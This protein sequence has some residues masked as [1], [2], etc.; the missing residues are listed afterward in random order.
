MFTV[1]DIGRATGGILQGGS[2]QLVT[3][4]STDSRSV[5]PGQ[6][7][8][9]LR[10]ERFDG[11]DFLPQVAERGV[12]VAL[13]ERQWVN[14]HAAP[15][16]LTLIVVPDTLRALGDL[17]IFHRQRFELPV[18]GITG[19][20]GK[21]T[22][23]EMLASILSF[24]GPGLKTSGNLNNLI[25]LPQMLFRLSATDRWAVLEMGMSEFGEIDRL[26]EIAAP[27][28]G[29][30]TNVFPAHLETLKN[31]AGVARA[32]GE[33][34]LRL[35]SGGVAVAN[36]DDPLVAALPAAPGVHRLEFGLVRG[37]VTARDIRP[38]GLTGQQFTLVLPKGEQ[39]VRLRAF[40][41]HNI[42][43]ALGAA[44][45]AY[46]FGV[47]PSLIREGLEEF[48]PYDKR[49]KVEELPGIVLVD[50][51]YNAN[52]ASMAAAL[53]TVKEIAAGRRVVA[54][55]GDMLELGEE[56]D[57]A[58]RQLGEQVAAAADRL[59]VLGE[60]SQLVA[61]GARSAGMAEEQVSQATS[62][63]EIVALLKKEATGNDLVLVKGS[64]GMR[65][66]QVAQALRNI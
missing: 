15:P 51:S 54:V 39:Q 7:F 37:E 1:A 35:P 56:S 59:F 50:D 46:A 47:K 10:G 32:K 5:E 19:S 61:Q 6:L 48:T 17:A 33:L 36:G 60:C 16:G 63:D 22:T 38:L 49:L 23:K 24:T 42:V 4:V 40:G 8:V 20:N 57:A 9:P 31:V 21:T 26:A 13:V 44:A 62:H 34:F 43:N 30:V 52:P 3:A 45:A 28:I 41:R 53:A 64:R 12:T 29:I 11:H 27:S 58:H 66:E 65:M 18:V 14:S 55:L 2:E 25:G